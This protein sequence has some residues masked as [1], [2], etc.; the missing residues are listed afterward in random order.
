[1]SF[2]VIE[3]HARRR[4]DLASVQE[5]T[6]AIARCCDG[7]NQRRLPFRWTKDADQV[8]TKPTPQPTASNHR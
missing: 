4:G 6:A 1:V 5:L 8:L 2:A 7:C 3:R